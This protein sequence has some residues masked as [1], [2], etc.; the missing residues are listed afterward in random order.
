M[1]SVFEH[2][3]PSTSTYFRHC[4]QLQFVSRVVK[5]KWGVCQEGSLQC[6]DDM[7]VIPR[8]ALATHREASHEQSDS[9]SKEK[10][11]EPVNLLAKRRPCGYAWFFRRLERPI[12]EEKKSRCHD[13]DAGSQYVARAP[14]EPAGVVRDG[15]SCEHEA[16]KCT[17]PAS[18]DSDG[19]ADSSVPSREHLSRH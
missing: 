7:R 9:S 1:S 15:G 5:V 18:G 17:K 6:T 12:K 16:E 3:L 19:G 11:T 4:S 13:V 10:G 14:R 2:V 8:I